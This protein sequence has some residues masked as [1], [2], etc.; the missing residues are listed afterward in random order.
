MLILSIWFQVGSVGFLFTLIYIFCP[1]N[2]DMGFTV[3]FIWAGRLDYLLGFSMVQSG[4]W[5]LGLQLILLNMIG[6][7]VGF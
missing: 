3:D 7:L 1:Y 2:F 6:N 4:F 5:S